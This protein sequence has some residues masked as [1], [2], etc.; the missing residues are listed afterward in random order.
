MKYTSQNGNNISLF[1]DKM[2]QAMMILPSIREVT[3]LNF[4]RGSER[5]D[6]YRSILQSLQVNLE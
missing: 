6:V 4:G 3:G 5:P 2:L 1:P